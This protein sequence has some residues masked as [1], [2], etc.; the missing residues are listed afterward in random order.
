M[1][2]PLGMSLVGAGCNGFCVVVVGGVVV[3]VI[4]GYWSDS[5]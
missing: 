1:G 2:H 4:V 3:V 5:L